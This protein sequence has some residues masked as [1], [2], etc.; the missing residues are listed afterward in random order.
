[1]EQIIFTPLEFLQYHSLEL[2]ACVVGAVAC[3][4]IAEEVLG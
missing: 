1:M 3:V 4:W 2:L